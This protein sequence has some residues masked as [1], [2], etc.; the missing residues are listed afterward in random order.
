VGRGRLRRGSMKHVASCT[1]TPGIPFPTTSPGAKWPQSASSSPGRGSRW[2]RGWTGCGGQSGWARGASP[3]TQR[4]FRPSSGGGTRRSSMASA[5]SSCSILIARRLTTRTR[6][7]DV[8]NKMQR[9][10]NDFVKNALESP[11][12]D[13]V[14]NQEKNVVAYDQITNNAAFLTVPE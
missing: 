10:R 9:R 8:F 5:P 3:E 6:T 13:V 14:P 7:N 4:C 12:V 1:G 11:A 2:R